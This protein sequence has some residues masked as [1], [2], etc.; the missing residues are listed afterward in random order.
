MPEKNVGR[1]SPVLGR[2]G[3]AGVGSVKATDKIRGLKLLSYEERLR[4]LDLFSLKM[5]RQR[6]ELTNA[7]KVVSR[8]WSQT[9][10]NSAQHQDKWQW[11][12][13]G[14]DQIPPGYEE[15]LLYFEG[16]RDWKSACEISCRLAQNSHQ[17]NPVQSA[18]GEPVLAGALN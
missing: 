9:L 12:Q 13:T 18:L 11:A 16:Y 2:Q 8:G 15:K 10:Y 14:T 17:H 3:T 5:R 6:G 7:H 1:S 4:V